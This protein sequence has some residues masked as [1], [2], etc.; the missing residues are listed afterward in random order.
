MELSSLLFTLQGEQIHQIPKLSLSKDYSI[1]IGSE[2]FNYCKEQ[3][4]F[5]SINAFDH[6]ESNSSPFEIL[7]DQNPN[8]SQVSID[9]LKVAFILIDSLFHSRTQIEINQANASSFFFH[10]EILDNPYL[11]SKCAKVLPEKPQHFSFCFKQI[12]FLS[13][14]RINSLNDIEISMNGMILKTNRILFSCLSQKI[15]KLHS[16]PP[17]ISIHVHPKDFSCFLSFMSLL[18][19]FP[20]NFSKFDIKSIISVEKILNCSSILSFIQSQIQIPSNVY[21]ATEFLQFYHCNEL[22]EYFEKSVSILA[23][24]LEEI[25]FEVLNS[26][27]YEILEQ[28]FS[29]KDLKIPNEDFLLT[30]IFH[31]IQNDQNK[32]RLYQFISFPAVSSNVLKHEFSNLRPEEIDSELLEALKT[33]LFCEIKTEGIPT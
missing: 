27:S 6:F 16:L 25:S 29:S 28:I 9:D 23:S 5:F 24:Q 26:F 12:Q 14:R 32:R 13:Q 17:E 21:E 2:T 33:R 7:I 1:K 10:G 11:I 22:K 31:L 15:S 18:K 3:L 30:L 8:P 20:I 19:G 4:I